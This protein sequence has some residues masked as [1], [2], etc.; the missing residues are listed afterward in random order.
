[1]MTPTTY[2]DNKPWE[3]DGSSDPRPTVL[4]YGHDFFLLHCNDQTVLLNFEGF[5]ELE[6][7]DLLARQ[8]AWG[9][10]VRP[11]RGLLSPSG[12]G[13]GLVGLGVES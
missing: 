7:F 2:R 8:H 11:G 3:K 1:M 6:G 12:G 13:W 9:A 5:R 10:R 4:R